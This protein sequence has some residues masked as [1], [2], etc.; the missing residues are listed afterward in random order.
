M[1]AE[2]R[3][4]VRQRKKAAEAAGL[5]PDNTRTAVVEELPL[6]EDEEDAERDPD[7]VKPRPT[8]R[9]RQ[10]SE[11]E[12]NPWVDVLRVLTF[13]VLASAGLSYLISSGDTFTWGIKQPPKYLQRAYWEEKFVR[14]LPPPYEF[15]ASRL[16]WAPCSA[17]RGLR[18]A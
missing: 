9:A 2:T 15:A 5:D 18:G 14:H 3:G 1:P 13:L 16:P 8:P 17:S 7:P 12:Y 6:T 10:R 11:D 4:S